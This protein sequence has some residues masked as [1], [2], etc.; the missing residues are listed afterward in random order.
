MKRRRRIEQ[1]KRN[2]QFRERQKQLAMRADSSARKETADPL[3]AGEQS[4]EAQQSGDQMANIAKEIV[5]ALDTEQ[6]DGDTRPTNVVES[7]MIDR[8]AAFGAQEEA[9]EPRPGAGDITGQVEDL[10]Q[11]LCEAI[12]A[13]EQDRVGIGDVIRGDAAPLAD[14]VA[15]D[16]KPVAGQP[17]TFQLM[18]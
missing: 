14:N 5:A 17:D 12:A 10:A 1:Q 8:V 16:E 9:D 4:G 3:K 13:D 2:Q 18:Q 6:R 15:G 7:P 11:D